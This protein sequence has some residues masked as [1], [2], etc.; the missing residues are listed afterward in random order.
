MRQSLI[1][2]KLHAAQIRAG[3]HKSGLL[4]FVIDAVWRVPL[5]TTRSC[6]KTK[7]RSLHRLALNP[8]T[9]P[10]GEDPY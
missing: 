9:A 7:T 3:A 2:E 6:S 10:F 5:K 8:R 1:K 4:I